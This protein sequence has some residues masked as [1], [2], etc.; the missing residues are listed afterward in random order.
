ML[1]HRPHQPRKP[2]HSLRAMTIAGAVASLL[3]ISIAAP[4]SGVQRAPKKYVP[5]VWHADDMST[6]ECGS[7]PRKGP[8]LSVLITWCWAEP[9]PNPLAEELVGGQW[10]AV[11][12]VVPVTPGDGKVCA[13]EAIQ[14]T[15]TVTLPVKPFVTHAYR[16]TLTEDDTHLTTVSEVR[17][18]CVR[19]A[20]STRT[21][22]A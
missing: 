15:W 7:R 20:V 5:C 6:Y 11:N 1:G 21:C 14:A 19:P 8:N 17:H 22:D 10:V 16:I 3:L 13:P 9:I 4:A 12:V 18:A 2:S